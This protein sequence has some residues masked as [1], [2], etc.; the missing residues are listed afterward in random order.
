MTCVGAVLRAAMLASLVPAIAH[1]EPQRS[2]AGSLQLDYLAVPT[3]PTPRAYTFDGA[4]TELSLKMSVDFTKD[5]S[6]TVKMCFACHGFEAAAAFVD[7]HAADEL[8]VRVGRMT[9]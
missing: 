4:T 1:A 9:P 8:S 7:L 3:E 6:A 2:L 5:A